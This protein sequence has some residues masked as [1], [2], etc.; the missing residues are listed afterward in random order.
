[1]QLKKLHSQDL[2]NVFEFILNVSMYYPSQF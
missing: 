2:H 1:M